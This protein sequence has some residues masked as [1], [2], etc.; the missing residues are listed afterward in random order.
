[1]I[2]RYALIEL[3]EPKTREIAE[4]LFLCDNT[5]QYTLSEHSSEAGIAHVAL[6][7]TVSN[8]P[9]KRN[10]MPDAGSGTFTRNVQ[11]GKN[12]CTILSRFHIDSAKTTLRV[13]GEKLALYVPPFE[14]R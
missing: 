4:G 6:H 9:R 1:M 10:L 11:G 5:H 2:R 3:N 14:A 7:L 8:I 13:W 12:S